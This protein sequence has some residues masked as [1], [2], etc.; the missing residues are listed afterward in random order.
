MT[1]HRFVRTFRMWSLMYTSRSSLYTSHHERCIRLNILD[2]ALLSFSRQRGSDWRS[3]GR[4][5]VSKTIFGRSDQC[6][7]F[8]FPTRQPTCQLPAV[9]VYKH[10]EVEN[11]TLFT[12]YLEYPSV[13]N[14]FF[15]FGL[16]QKVDFKIFG[17]WNYSS[18]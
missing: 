1:Y 12:H 11:I 8:L 7:S 13:E 14:H 15:F 18:L 10:Y 4:D 17:S 16:N 6:L 3:C 5:R 2:L 9:T